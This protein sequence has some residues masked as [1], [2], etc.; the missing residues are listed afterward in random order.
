MTESKPDSL[1][2]WVY[3]SSSKDELYVYLSG[4][5]RFEDLPKNLL[6]LLGKPELVMDLELH[7]RRRLARA[8][9][10]Q[11]IQSLK[12]RGYYLQLPPELRPE[13]HHGD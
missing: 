8:D 5:D 7:P 11:V 4:K 1:R 13:L 9:V 6:R 10:E 12:T 2:C 3:R